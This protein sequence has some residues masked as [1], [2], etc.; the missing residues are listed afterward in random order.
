M[1]G[2]KDVVEFAVRGA[3]KGDGV[4]RLREHLGASAVLFAGDDVT[5]EDG[6]NAL[7]G[8]DVGIKVGE[9][10]S[11]ARYRV[12]DPEQLADALELLADARSRREPAVDAGVSRQHP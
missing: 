3:T 12:A 5:D 10:V 9:G 7:T 8:A 11:A 6:F 4:Q 2:G 1:R